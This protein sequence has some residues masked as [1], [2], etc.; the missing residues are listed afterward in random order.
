MAGRANNRIMG[1]GIVARI[2]HVMG[3]FVYLFG[4]RLDRLCPYITLLDVSNAVGNQNAQNLVHR[5]VRLLLRK[6][7]VDKVVGVRQEVTFELFD[8]YLAIKLE[9]LDMLACLLD[10]LCIGVQAVDQVTVICA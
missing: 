10:V 7:E 2:V 8:R 1:H 3:P 6:N 9:R 4:T 5:Y